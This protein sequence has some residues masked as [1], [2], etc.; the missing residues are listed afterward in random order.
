MLEYSKN[1]TKTTGSFWNYYR[2]EPNNPPLVGNPPTVNY[3][4]DPITNSESFKYKS[5]ITGKTS[6]ANQE[7]SEDT[8]LEDTKTKKNHE[9]VVPVKHLSNF[10]RTLDMPV[11]NC[12]VSLA[13]T[14]S[15]TF[16]DWY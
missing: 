3:N 14:W 15:E 10:W 4:A 7:S 8:E 6:N 2:D 1:Y 12:E 16:F 13:L 5:S 9:I 11:I